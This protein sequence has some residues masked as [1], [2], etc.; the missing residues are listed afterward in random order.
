MPLYVNLKQYIQ[1]C[2]AHSF[3]WIGCLSICYTFLKFP[4]VH[5]HNRISW[6]II[7]QRAH[8]VDGDGVRKERR[9]TALKP[10]HLY[11]TL[12]QQPA[13]LRRWSTSR[14]RAVGCNY[15][16]SLFSPLTYSVPRARPMFQL[17]KTDFRLRSPTFQVRAF[18]KTARRE[19]SAWGLKTTQRRRRHALYVHET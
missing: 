19:T 14:W 5:Y 15:L 13:I 7:I 17:M 11:D 16:L 3:W 2:L 9:R 10:I 12:L 18:G 1:L 8:K 6:I 4:R